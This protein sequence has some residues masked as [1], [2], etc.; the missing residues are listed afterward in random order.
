MQSNRF[1]SWIR[2]S[3]LTR[4]QDRWVGGVCGGIAEYLDW[5]P[6]LVRAL[7]AASVLVFGFGAAFYAIAWMLMPDQADGTILAEEL[8]AGRWDWV[9]LGPFLCLALAIVVP[10]PH[11][12]FGAA[13]FAAGLFFVLVN[14]RVRDIR[15][16]NYPGNAPTAPNAQSQA[17]GFTQPAR[18][19]PVAGFTQPASAPRPAQP[20]QQQP[21]QPA[22]PGPAFAAAEAGAA[23]WQPNAAAWT[24]PATYAY[25]APRTLV[26]PKYLRRTPAGFPVV[27]GVVGVILLTAAWV[28]ISSQGEN[29]H[30]EPIVRSALIGAAI[31]CL[32]LGVVILVLG[33]VGRRAG[34]LVP[35]AWLAAF[36]AF[37]V[38]TAGIGYTYVLADMN[39]ANSSYRHVS[40]TGYKVYGSSD[41]QLAQLRAG[42]AFEGPSPLTGDKANID[43][44]Q[45]GNLHG[46]HAL[47]VGQGSG[48]KT[49]QSACPTGR[50]NLTAYK[51][52]VFVT[53]P[54][55]CSYQFGNAMQPFNGYLAI[56]SIGG[57]HSATMLRYGASGGVIGFDGNF[58]NDGSVNPGNKNYSWYFD[59]NVSPTNGPEL[60]INASHV[61]D[62]TVNVQYQSESQL[63]GYVATTSKETGK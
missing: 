53:L 39:L 6:T 33:L 51:T 9:F 42:M 14:K 63:P 36:L 12:G 46:R 41:A 21:S 18:P 13:F 27:A 11:F 23:V 38:A 55:G 15:R 3:R 34:G 22:Q 40:V 45:Y 61:V 43:L 24:P 2:E 4:S 26:Q 7:M 30:L 60:T 17:G 32:L 35:F 44:S 28:L 56:R 10:V 37:A 47:T 29:N 48:K 50:I 16:M 20:D 1:F 5:S 59:E 54:D 57:W 25:R 31:V 52:R 19:A 62:A 58:I 8:I 49:V